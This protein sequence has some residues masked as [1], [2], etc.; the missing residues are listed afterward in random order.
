MALEGEIHWSEG[1]FLQPHHLQ[2][3]QRNITERFIRQS[4]MFWSYPYGVIEAKI[5]DDQLENMRVSFDRLRVIMPSGLEVNVPDNTNLPS[6][7]IK[8]AFASTSDTLTISIGV[9]VWY[10]SRGNVIERGDDQDRLAKRTY[11][12]TETE[13]TDEN[14]GENPQPVQIR[15]INARLLLENDDRSDLEVLP[16]L[17]INRAAGEDIGLPRRDPKYIPP[18]FVVSGSSVLRELLHDLTSQI[19]ASRNELVVQIN[20]G[21]FSIENMR[22][23]Q[24]E[25]MLRLRTLNR[26]SS[27][28]GSLISISSRVAPFQM[29]LLLRQLLAELA[30]LRPDRDMY[31]VVGYDHDNLA[32]AFNELSTSIRNLLKG[33]GPPRYFEL[34]FAIDH[35]QKIYV[36]TLTEEAISEP[37]EY[38][39]GITTKMDPSELA[40]LVEDRDK[41][42]M[43]PQ[44][45]ANQRVFGVQLTREK[46]EPNELP[47][48]VDLH[49]FRVMRGESARLWE[50]I[51][52]EKTVAVRWPGAETSDFKITLY[53]TVPGSGKE[54][55]K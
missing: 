30:A 12:V 26:F 5:S 25:Q 38:F 41:F 6:L 42:K 43:M 55:Q 2:I 3:M 51:Q 28:L 7:D 53:M 19:M 21:G 36:A 20:R 48:R 39:L 11:I 24:F 54:A 16:L 33:V 35:E 34:P 37:N 13:R 45:L 27:Q 4:R 44:S 50:R 32:I 29:Y 31:E 40:K 9:P 15:Q 22:G 18:C 17:K 47:H 10:S 14:T 1:L 8:Q 52:Q 46:Y 23:S 49:Y